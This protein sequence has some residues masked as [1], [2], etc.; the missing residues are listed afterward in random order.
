[1]PP[2]NVAAAR[3]LPSDTERVMQRTVTLTTHLAAPP[4]TVRQHVG[5]S[6]LLNYITR[7]LIRFTPKAGQAFPEDWTP[8]EYKAW[9]WL[10]GLLPVGWQAIRISFPEP[11]NATQFI[12]DN[13]YGPLIKRWDHMIEIRSDGD[14]THYTDRVI[15]EA[16]LLTPLIAAFAQVFYGHRQK[17][18]RKLVNS[19]FDYTA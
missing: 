12:R 18:W 1:M 15:I 7:P 2:V 13:G 17:R 8:G 14:G 10:F 19:R 5:T 6:R 4:E 3:A 9:M 16:G 11:E